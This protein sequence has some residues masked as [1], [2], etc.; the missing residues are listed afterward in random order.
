MIYLYTT[1]CLYEQDKSLRLTFRAVFWV[2]RKCH[3]CRK[4]FANLFLVIQTQI[5]IRLLVKNCLVSMQRKVKILL[6]SHQRVVT[7]IWFYLNYYYT[8]KNCIILPCILLTVLGFLLV[9]REYY[10]GIN[11]IA[12]SISDIFS[13]FTFS[14][15][16][17]QHKST[18]VKLLNFNQL[19]WISS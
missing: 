11:N 6:L 14:L 2:E 4:H 16:L 9:Q 3:S 15:Q 7:R 13:H 5:F 10:F 1:L 19:I 8:G 17:F 12:R 18:A